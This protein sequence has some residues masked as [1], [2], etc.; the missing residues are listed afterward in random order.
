MKKIIIYSIGLI[1]FS[2]CKK[3]VNS[4]EIKN[5]KVISTINLMFSGELNNSLAMSQ[6]K[7]GVVRTLVPFV[8]LSNEK[9]FRYKLVEKSES[10]EIFGF[11]VSLDKI[12]PAVDFFSFNLQKD[13]PPI[14]Y[15]KSVSSNGYFEFNK[16][17]AASKVENL[18]LDLN[19]GEHLSLY[20]G[21]QG[22]A[23]V[24]V[25]WYM[26]TYDGYTGN[27]LFETF[28]YSTC[29]DPCNFNSGSGSNSSGQ[30]LNQKLEEIK[31]G[32]TSEMMTMTENS[33]NPNNRS[34]FYKWK[35]YKQKANLWYFFSTELGYHKRLANGTWVW[36]KLEHGGIGKSG[37]V[38]GGSINVSMLGSLPQVGIYTAGIQLSCVFESSISWA[39]AP[40]SNYTP[41]TSNS[42]FW[43]V[44]E[45]GA[46]IQ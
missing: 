18:N 43:N 8:K 46:N 45:L 34:F 6:S 28:L 25:D 33:S 39:G 21:C 2:S 37:S 16:V 44:N 20:A 13:G 26:V 19:L 4:D 31:G 7:G 42:P 41:F 11:V 22:A 38:A 35:I 32:V 9:S 23:P 29:Y 14:I 36:D 5:E 24:C 12:S 27:V 30:T 15:K 10:G 40:V 17:K 3:N 1:L